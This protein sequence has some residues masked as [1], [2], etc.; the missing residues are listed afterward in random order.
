MSEEAT[1]LAKQADEEAK[2]YLGENSLQQP[3]DPLKQWKLQAPCFPNLAQIAEALLAI[4]A[5]SSTPEQAFSAAG[6]ATSRRQVSFSSE[7][8]NHLFL[9][10]T[11]GLIRTA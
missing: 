5:T 2:S 11:F 3:T 7:N 10:K 4:S 9:N 8:V 1:D 6:V